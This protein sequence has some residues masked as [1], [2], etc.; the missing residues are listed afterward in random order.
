MRK[1]MEKGRRLRV[2]VLRA[3]RRKLTVDPGRRAVQEALERE[4]GASLANLTPL[5]ERIAATDRL[6]DL[7]VY[8]LYGL[9]EEEAIVESETGR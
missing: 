3:N 1:T 6:T 7:I 5:K 8:R 4:F 2:V 9:T